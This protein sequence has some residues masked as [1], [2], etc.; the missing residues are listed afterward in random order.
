MLPNPELEYDKGF[1]ERGR[2]NHSMPRPLRVHLKDA[3][4]YVTLEGPEGEPIFRDQD[5]YDKYLELLAEAKKEF[6]FKIFSYSLL[7]DG[8]HLLIQASDDFPV[9]IIMQRITPL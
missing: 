2:E 4:Y 7:P 5:D 6:H 3:V 8:L 1:R 9:S